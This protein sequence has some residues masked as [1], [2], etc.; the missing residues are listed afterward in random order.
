MTVIR[1]CHY[2]LS[3]VIA[4]ATSIMMKM[5]SNQAQQ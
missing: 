3:P 5:T 1:H 2:F 4:M